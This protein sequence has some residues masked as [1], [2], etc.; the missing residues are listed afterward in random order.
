MAGGDNGISLPVF[1][2]KGIRDTTMKKNVLFLIIF[3]SCAIISGAVISET[4]ISDQ[5]GENKYV[6]QVGAFHD[7]PEKTLK[8]VAH[9]GVIQQE[10]S[11]DLIR[12]TV[13]SFHSKQEAETLLV[14]IKKQYPEAFIRLFSGNKGG[15]TQHNHTGGHQ[16]PHFDEKE[17][18]K[19]QQLTEDQRAHA[20]YLDGQLH[21]KYGDEFTRV[22]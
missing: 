11:G 9:Y 6:I 20:V 8:D 19:W 13:G 5:H 1:L 18:E 15:K 2:V 12:L 21:L 22:E 17:M 3:F 10:K 7:V 16:H 4:I 14:D